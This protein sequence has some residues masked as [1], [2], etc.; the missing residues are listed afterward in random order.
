MRESVICSL[1]GK[2]LST[3]R[4][5]RDHE[6]KCNGAH[7]LQC[8]VCWEEFPTSKRK[9][10]HCLAAS[11]TA[12]PKPG[13]QTD[14]PGGINLSNS[15]HNHVSSHIDNSSHVDNSTNIDNS[16]NA[17][18][19]VV[20]HVND[21]HR[22]NTRDSVDTVMRNPAPIQLANERQ[23]DKLEEALAQAAYWGTPTNNSVFGIESHG[24]NMFCQVNGKRGAINRNEGFSRMM[25]TVRQV[26]RAPEVS[27]LLGP[28]VRL[29]DLTEIE[30]PKDLADLRA[31]YAVVVENGG[32]FGNSILVPEAR[33][34]FVPD[35][36]LRELILSAAEHVTGMFNH[37]VRHFWPLVLQVCRR[38]G[39]ADGRWFVGA[40][41]LVGEPS[42][43]EVIKRIEQTHLEYEYPAPRELHRSQVDRT[44]VGWELLA[45]PRTDPKGIPVYIQYIVVSKI[46]AAMLAITDEYAMIIHNSPERDDIDDLKGVRERIGFVDYDFLNNVTSRILHRMTK[47]QSEGV[48]VNWDDY[49]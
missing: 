28:K 36:E 3:P 27:E 43:A 9:S 38:F 10:R 31:R 37:P 1:C 32:N 6:A 46:R 18:C 14:S 42:E 48:P 40:G 44:K 2:E 20:L 49:R 8:P 5:R 12:R 39:Y 21:F 15:N 23:H 11:C 25:G 41:G 33:P 19:S 4:H 7:S 47:V 30:C 34:Y 17:P 24:R 13:T 35:A 29:T 45:A 22:T 16:V 26:A